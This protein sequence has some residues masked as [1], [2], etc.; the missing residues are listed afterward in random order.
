MKKIILSVFT[1]L[2]AFAATSA[3]AQDFT[4]ATDTVYYTVGGSIN[5]HND[6]VAQVSSVKIA[7]NVVYNN[8]PS[9][10]KNGFGICDNVACY[11]A[12][13][14]N[15]T[16]TDTTAVFSTTCD[17]HLQLDLRS[18]TTSG[19]YYVTLHLM[20]VG[21]AGTMKNITF[22]INKWPTGINKVNK[23]TD[24][25]LYPNPAANEVN[26]VFDPNAE[27]RSAAVYNL[28]GKQVSAYRITGNSAKLDLG[29]VPSGIYFVRLMDAQG[30][31]VTTK[32]F[33]H[34]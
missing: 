1:A 13:V 16:T 15:G 17:F 29:N 18:A 30:N 8:I 14:L 31:I 33:T 22:A 10:W 2:C 6:I 23:N 24:V 9:D 19:T 11:P 26:L 34:Q 7:W 25:M 27:I 4:T 20:E 12:S 28:I 32:R 21:G 5:V 3:T